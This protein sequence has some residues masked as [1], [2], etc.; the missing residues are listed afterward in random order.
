MK[1]PV[2]S[3]SRA[4][5]IALA[6]AIVLS[7]ALAVRPALELRGFGNDQGYSPEQPIAYSHQLHAGELQIACLYCHFGAEKS[8]SAGIPP[9]SICMNCHMRVTSPFIEVR[10]EAAAAEKE[11]RK[12]RVL[13]S[14]NIRKIYD[15]LLALTKGKLPELS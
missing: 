6:A 14:D 2:S 12:S 4:L 7:L 1:D 15:A 5:T 9:L 10:A 8:R 3:H 11:K 13:M